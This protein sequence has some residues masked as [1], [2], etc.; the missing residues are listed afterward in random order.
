MGKEN[1]LLLPYKKNTI[2]ATVLGNLLSSGPGEVIVVT[3]YEAERVEAGFNGELPF[4]FVHNPRHEL[5]MTTSIQA[6]VRAAKGDA[7][8]ICLPDMVLIT[9]EEYSFLQ[10]AFQEVQRADSRCI[11]VPV[12]KELKGNPVLFSS[13]YQADILDHT[14][15][16]GCKGIVQSNI[17]HLHRIVMPSDHILRDFDY[18]DEYEQLIKE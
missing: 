5:G 2:L 18:P 10:Q 11:C 14:E 3:G 7:Y 13:F 12:Y 6:G 4:R 1:K 8:M 9:P 17:S 16:E 15:K